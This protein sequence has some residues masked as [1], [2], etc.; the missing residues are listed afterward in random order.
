VAV[1]TSNGKFLTVLPA[2]PLSE[3]GWEI[4]IVSPADWSTVIATLGSWEN[5]SFQDALSA[6]GT[7]VLELDRN[8]SRL[9]RTVAGLTG[10]I[11][12]N[13]CLMRVKHDGLTKFEW[14]LE[15][16]DLP[17]IDED[18]NT[19][20]MAGR[21][22][23]AILENGIVL[24]ANYPVT[25]VDPRKFSG[26]SK[27]SAWYVLF[28]E[29][30]ARGCFPQVTLQFSQ[31]L[32]TD[33]IGWGDTETFEVEAG[34]DLL[35]LLDQWTAAHN[36]TWRM[37]PGFKLQVWHHYG[38]T[39]PNV[40][41]FPSGDQK[42]QKLARSRAEL[43]NVV[44][45]GAADGVIA[46]AADTSTF[47]KWGRRESWVDAGDTESISGAQW[48]ADANLRQFKDENPARTYEIDFLKNGRE[49]Y[50]DWFLGD[51]IKVGTNTGYY[52]PVRPVA[53]TI[54]V[55]SGNVTTTE[56]MIA[57][58]QEI[59]QPPVVKMKKVQKKQ[60]GKKTKSKASA[61]KAP[62]SAAVNAVKSA[63]W[64][65]MADV[66]VSS[67]NVGAVAVW[68]GTVWQDTLLDLDLLT[69]VSAGTP[70]DNE[71]LT[72]DDSLNLWV[73]SPAAGGAS[74]KDR[75]WVRGS[76]ADA[77]DDEFEGS[78]LSGSWVRV[79]E[80]GTSGRVTY[81]QQAGVLSVLNTGG[82][83]SPRVHG[84]LK[85]YAL[86]V[87]KSLQCGV[88]IQGK[89]TNFPFSGIIVT[90]GD[91]YGAGNQMAA[92]LFID[93]DRRTVSQR[94][95]T[96]WNS[97]AATGLNDFVTDRGMV[98][99][100]LYRDTGNVWRIYYSPDAVSWI[101]GGSLTQAF[102]PSHIGI[103]STSWGATDAS[104][105]TYEYIRVI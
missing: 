48:Y 82:D 33:M 77:Q 10:R 80:G 17:I 90:D 18:E 72:W 36:L 16:P 102:T 28:Q 99:L 78:S 101:S 41:Y 58:E 87:G 93:G 64:D 2:L 39:R 66:S 95:F 32:S 51:T 50:V 11:T 42:S 74:I 7:G 24:P 34:D 26:T 21:G 19:I 61:R 1:R 44:Y 9:D 37:A 31:Y 103:L 84:L 40:V 3:I 49:I 86:P 30:K 98:H 105:A 89:N 23:G 71:V 27:M 47:T 46:V 53:I 79:D 5:M 12:D 91:T 55:D 96:S 70:A 52:A 94:R 85:P 4:D 69:D 45:A 25:K 62:T 104:V 63:K 76:G 20:V 54:G 56:I 92:C 43:S 100:R 67:P 88:N 8:D 75:R 97:N 73:P 65:D 6:T 14:L 59:P 57:D 22:T 15:E 83:G 29:A 38:A 35:E 81:T 13:L 60:K 68:T